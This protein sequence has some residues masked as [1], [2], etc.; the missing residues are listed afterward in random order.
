MTGGLQDK[1]SSFYFNSL[2]KPK[3]LKRLLKQSRVFSLFC[4][5]YAVLDITPAYVAR[6]KNY[7][8]HTSKM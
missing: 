5:K 1:T 4:S 2:K 8:S 3:V 6:S 7:R